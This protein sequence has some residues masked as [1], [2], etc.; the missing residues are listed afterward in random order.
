MCGSANVSGA[1]GQEIAVNEVR[2]FGIIERLIFLNSYR[3]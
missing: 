2:A 1:E 3:E